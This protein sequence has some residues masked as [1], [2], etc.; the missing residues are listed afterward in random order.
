MKLKELFVSQKQIKQAGPQIDRMVETE[1]SNRSLYDE[2]AAQ[3]ELFFGLVGATGADLRMVEVALCDALQNVRYR[4][5]MIKLS[6][7]L[8]EHYGVPKLDSEYERIKRAM[9]LGNGMRL[10]SNEAT[11]LLGVLEI[12][13]LREQHWLA[14]RNKLPPA[15]NPDEFPKIPLPRRAYICHS[16]KHPAEV[17]ILREIYGDSFYVISAYSSRAQRKSALEKRIAESEIGKT[18][19][20]RRSKKADVLMRRDYI[21]AEL[22]NGQNLRDTFPLADLFVN[23]DDKSECA[24]AIAR[25]I[26][27]IFGDTEQTPTIDEYCMFHAKGAA[28]RSGDLGR[29]VGAIVATSRGDVLSHGT[30]EAP[31]AHGGQPWT[32]DTPDGRGVA[33]DNDISDERKKS[34]LIDLLKR[35]SDNKRISGMDSD[36]INS[37]AEEIFSKKRPRWMKGAE[38]LELIGFYRSVH[39]ET[40][41]IINASRLGISVRG[42]NLYVTAFPCHECARHILAAG[43]ERVFY[44]EPYPKS[45]AGEHYP[46]AIVI[47]EEPAEDKIPFQ[48]FVGISPRIY[49]SFFEALERKN[50]DGSIIKWKP[51]E[52]AVRYYHHWLAYTAKEAAFCSDFQEALSKQPSSKENAT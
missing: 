29:Q 14:F 49:L 15:T 30:N 23:A 26:R 16:L 50:K 18:M 5:H 11:A 43:I 7:L 19:I 37:L 41:A 1:K 24:K 12:R 2:Q 4:P 36:Q 31:R 22:P 21:E 48:Q 13:R 34:L 47:D 25:F 35:L 52:C 10:I 6:G 39:G 9:D 32:G 40:A 27:M 17:E 33:Q 44:I 38:V 3:S 51:G 45:L 20:D 46:E 42:G 28:L 8:E